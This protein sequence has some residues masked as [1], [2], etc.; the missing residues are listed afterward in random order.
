MLRLRRCAYR[1]AYRLL[2]LAGFVWPPRGQGAQALLVCDGQVLLV[3]H[4]YGPRR[5]E[6]PGGGIKRGEQPIEAL[7]RELDEEL[8]LRVP[9]AVSIAVRHG[10]GRQHR[11]LT[12]LY[13]V[14][15]QSQLV[16]P[17]GV[18]ID[19]ARWFDPAAPPARL[20]WMVRE[21]LAEAGP[22]ARP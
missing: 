7:R 1:V 14:E 18:E 12:H 3:R 5:W 22:S 17:D 13:R 16:D 8:G 4:S 21:A 11:Q 6:L 15:L 9:A 19:E 20:G 2:R 10:P